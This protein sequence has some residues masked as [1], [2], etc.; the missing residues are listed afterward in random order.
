MSEWMMP[1]ICLVLCVLSWGGLALMSL[2]GFA[3]NKK[4]A[5]RKFLEARREQ[6]AREQAQFRFAQDAMLRAGVT[7]PQDL[8]LTDIGL[9]VYRTP[10]HPKI[11]RTTPVMTD[12]RYLRPFAELKSRHQHRVRLEIYDSQGRLHFADEATYPRGNKVRIVPKTW[13][14]LE[15][16][17]APVGKWSL[18]IV[19]DDRLLGLMKFEW[20]VVADN[21]ILNQLRTDGEINDDLRQAVENGR[22]RK[23]SLDELLAGQEE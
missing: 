17:V 1:L 11:V 22:F 6:S 14:R 16:M 15:N 10:D 7:P 8:L 21:E 2:F 13:L 9:L 4:P 19:V 12:S 5:W 18:A 20:E 23:M 3:W